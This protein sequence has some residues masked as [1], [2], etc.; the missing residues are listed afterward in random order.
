[1]TSA[2]LALIW[3]SLAAV[4]RNATPVRV[5]MLPVVFQ[6]PAASD[7]SKGMLRPGM[8]PHAHGGR[9]HYYARRNSGDPSTRGGSNPDKR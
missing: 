7:G 3:E 5:S 1:M 2:N 9:E 4:I 6:E 8:G